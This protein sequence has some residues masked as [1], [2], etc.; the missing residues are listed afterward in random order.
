MWGPQGLL[1]DADCWGDG[2]AGWAGSFGKSA[3]LRRGFPG[4]QH[5]PCPQFLMETMSATP[6]Q[7]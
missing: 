2:S 6:S 4:L 1:S 3:A 5:F 7:V